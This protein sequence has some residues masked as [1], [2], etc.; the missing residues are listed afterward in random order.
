MTIFRYL[1]NLPLN[2][3][4]ASELRTSDYGRLILRTRYARNATRNREISSN[5]ARARLITLRAI[6]SLL[7]STRSA[8][9]I[10]AASRSASLRTRLIGFLGL[11]YVV[12]RTLE[13]ST[14]TLLTRRT[15]ATR[16]RGGSFGLYRGCLIWY[17]LFRVY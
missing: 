7:T 5:N 9:G 16:L 6:R 13:I 8:R 12:A 3:R 17:L 4:L 15:L 2:M 11:L 14:R 10:A 1:S